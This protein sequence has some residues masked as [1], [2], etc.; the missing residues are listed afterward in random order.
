MKGQGEITQQLL[1]QAKQARCGEISLI[2]Y[3][4]NQSRIMRDKTES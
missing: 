1:S 4:L 2:P 3:Q